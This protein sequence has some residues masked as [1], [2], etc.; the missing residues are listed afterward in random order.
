[1]SRLTITL[2]L[3]P[4][5]EGVRLDKLANIAGELEKFL[6]S[7]A[8]DC[9]VSVDP[10]EWVARQFYNGSMGAVVE[11]IGTVDPAVVTKFNAGIR[12][13]AR[14]DPSHDSFNGDY[15]ETTIKQFVQIGEKLDADEVVRVG[16]KDDD[17]ISLNELDTS[18]G[19]EQIA[20]RTT[21]AIEEAVL[22]PI[23]YLGSIQ[24]RL[25]T[26]FKE[27]DFIYVRDSVFGVLVKCNYKPS[28]YDTI[29]RAYKDKKAV[30]HVTGRIKSDRLSGVPKEMSVENIDRY[31]ELSDDEFSSVFGC[32]PS[33]IG[34][35]D[36]STYLD[37]VR[38]DGD[39]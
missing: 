20:K 1:M 23:Y 13:F 8:N 18:L 2:E 6:R 32:A 33:L 35:D 5:G 34:H 30:V 37:R 17:V 19:W 38:D 29:Y 10:G 9:G 36:A 22:S 24:G 31:D 15:S 7:L 12:R 14:F 11:H 21:V 39:A 27:S 26:W 16:L 4:G 3:N 25:G 28:L